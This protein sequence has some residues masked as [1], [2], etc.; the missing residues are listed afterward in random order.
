MEEPEVV[1]KLEQLAGDSGIPSQRRSAAG[2]DIGSP[3][4]RASGERAWALEAVV[5]NAI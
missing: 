2:S 3:C 1:A 5:G 4:R